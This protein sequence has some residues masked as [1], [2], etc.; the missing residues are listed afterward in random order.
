MAMEHATCDALSLSQRPGYNDKASDFDAGPADPVV[1]GPRLGPSWTVDVLCDDVGVERYPR[2][3]IL[4][5]SWRF[6]LLLGVAGMIG[7]VGAAWF[8]QHVRELRDDR[9]RAGTPVVSTVVEAREFQAAQVRYPEIR[10]QV[11]HGGVVRTEWLRASRPIHQRRAGDVVVV[12]IGTDGGLATRDGYLSERVQVVSTDTAI[13]GAV[14]LVLLAVVATSFA[15]SAA[16]RRRRMAGIAL[17]V[18]AVDGGVIEVTRDGEL[19]RS[20]WIRRLD[21]PARAR[22]VAVL[23]RHLDRPRLPLVMPVS[24]HAATLILRDPLVSTGRDPITYAVIGRA[25]G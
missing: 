25:L 8:V 15:G 12:H 11:V 16:W 14:I 18:A 2:A 3:R 23:G 21:R 20:R 4:W 22:A 6:T 1:P 5:S 7:T 9:V 10:V 17:F 19:F 24:R 13:A